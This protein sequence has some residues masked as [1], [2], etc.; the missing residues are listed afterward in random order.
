ML[1]LT[2]SRLQEG[3]SLST[4]A[5]PSFV[6]ATPTFDRLARPTLPAAPSQADVGAQAYWGYCLPCHGEKGQG[7]TAEFRETYP[8]EEQYCWARGCHGER[9]YEDGFTLPTFIPPVVG[10]KA[11]SKFPTAATLQGY[12]AAAMPWWKPGSLSE[13][14]NWQVTAFLLRENGLWDGRGDLDAANAETI[15]VG[16]PSATPTV[17][18]ERLEAAEAPTTA[19]SMDAWR[20]L[21]GIALVAFTIFLAVRVWRRREPSGR[22]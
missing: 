22:H 4:I 16:P 15:R 11:L 20:V 3:T 14:E 9:P 19:A 12:I 17:T 18:D 10:P 2:A 21:A 8:P 13:Q 6:V 5:E 1:L 7:L